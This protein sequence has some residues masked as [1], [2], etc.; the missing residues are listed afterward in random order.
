MG[1]GWALFIDPTKNGWRT[2]RSFA[3]VGS[4]SKEELQGKLADSRIVRTADSA[5]GNRRQAG[6]PVTQIQVVIDV[7]ELRAELELEPLAEREV[8]E[9]CHIPVE[10]SR[11]ADRVPAHN[12]VAT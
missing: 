7:E 1:P 2:G 8:F 5:E 3:G 9:K 4:R 11:A 12:T 6:C 10:Q